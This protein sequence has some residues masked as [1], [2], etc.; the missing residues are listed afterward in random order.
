MKKMTRL[1]RFATVLDSAVGHFFGSATVV[2]AATALIATLIASKSF[3]ILNT[4]GQII[5]IDLTGQ[6]EGMAVTPGTEQSVSPAMTNKGNVNMYMFIRFDVGTYTTAAG[7]NGS[8]V[9]PVYEF[10][11]DRSESSFWT[12]IEG[13]NL[14]QLIFAYGAE[15]ELTEVEP[16]EEIM[17]PGTLKCIVDDSSFVDLDDNDLKIKVTG[18]AIRSEDQSTIAYDC[19]QAYLSAG[20]E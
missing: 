17:L 18:C 5:S 3:E 2:F 1:N 13:E 7:E 12:Q 16:K 20:G 19:Y 10:T 9:K 11:V 8:T 4:G 15:S 14:G 6:V